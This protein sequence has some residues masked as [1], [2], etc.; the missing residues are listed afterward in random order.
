MRV[1]YPNRILVVEGSELGVSFSREAGMVPRHIF[2]NAYPILSLNVR[3]R[4]MDLA[5]KLNTYAF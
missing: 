5:P 1:L 4:H 3:I 2:D